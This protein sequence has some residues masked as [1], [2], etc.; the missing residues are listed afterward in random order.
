MPSVYRPLVNF[1]ATAMQAV[2][3][4]RCCAG[5]IWFSRKETFHLAHVLFT[6]EPVGKYKL[7]EGWWSHFL[8]FDLSR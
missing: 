2:L 4:W 6:P 5:I 3:I 1:V 8:Y 7:V